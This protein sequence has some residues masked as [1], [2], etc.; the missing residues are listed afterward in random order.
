MYLFYFI[1]I[2]KSV[3][4]GSELSSLKKTNWTSNLIQ[5]SVM[6]RPYYEN[7]I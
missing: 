5:M 4:N 3:E 6:F 7:V 2:E 1:F